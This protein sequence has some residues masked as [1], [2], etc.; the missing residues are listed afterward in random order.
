MKILLA[1]D[2][3]DFSKEATLKTCEIASAM[4]SEVRVVSAFEAPASIAAEPF[5]ITPE[6]YQDLVDG[7]KRVAESAAATAVTTIKERSPNTAVDSVVEMGRP[8]EVILDVAKNWGAEL[9]VAG[10][11]GIGFWGRTLTLLGSVSNAVAHNCHCPILIV[12]G[13][14]EAKNDG[15]R[16]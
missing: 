2:G 1:T 16:G 12:R 8:A 15:H 11:H 3:S 14:E 13:P 6:L 5:V 9:I 10:S 4:P 7:L